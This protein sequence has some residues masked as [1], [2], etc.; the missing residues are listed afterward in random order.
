MRIAI[1]SFWHVHAPNYIREARKNPGLELVAAW[2]AA[3]ERGRAKAK[4]F[5]LPFVDNLDELL[6]RKDIEGVVVQCPTTE[7]R[8][9]I[10]KATKA[11]KHIFSDKVL[12][13]TL[14]EA[15]EIVAAADAAKVVL[16]T[17]MPVLYH[18][19]VGQLKALIDSGRLGRLVNI[20][21]L[22][23]H[24]RAIDDTLPAGFYDPQ[25]SAGGV[26]VD[27][28]HVVYVLPLLV[29]RLPETA[30]SRF[31][32]FTNREV[33]DSALVVFDFADG[34]HVTLDV[35][36]VNRASPRMQ[37]EVNGT[38]GA[39]LFRADTHP[40]GKGAPEN[41]M[42][43]ARFGDEADFATIPFGEARPTPLSLWAE[44]AAQGRRAD[45]NIARALDLSLLNEVAYR[46]AAED[47][48]IPLSSI[49]G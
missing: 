41:A 23:C 13:P 32:S 2:D 47:K 36:F 4:E 33:E 9:V 43:V 5:D 10:L 25:E 15:K 12:A 8:D 49:K 28:C 21:M 29:G 42:F 7:H 39:V 37:I 45:D 17:G 1:L 46:S 30:Y 27:M 18:D 14:R 16:V 3:R 22:S 38:D 35:S 24:G 26:L 34:L 6:A 31:A 20:K 44:N 11:G 48:P 19:Y 40:G